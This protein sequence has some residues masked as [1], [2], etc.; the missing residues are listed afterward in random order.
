MLAIHLNREIHES[1]FKPNK[2]DHVTPVLATAVKS[3]LNNG[4]AAKHKRTTSELNDGSAA[5]DSSAKEAEVRPVTH[6][7]PLTSSQGNPSVMLVLSERHG[8]FRYFQ[9][10]LIFLISKTCPA[11]ARKTFAQALSGAFKIQPCKFGSRRFNIVCNS[12]VP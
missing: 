11:F 12:L 2:Q 7:E 3:E 8:I 9:Y 4:N 1:G 6:E 10:R 5:K